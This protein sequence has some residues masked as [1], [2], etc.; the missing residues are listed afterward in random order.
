MGEDAVRENAILF[1]PMGIILGAVVGVADFEIQYQRSLNRY[2][3]LYLNPELA[4]SI[5]GSVFGIGVGGYFFP[6][7]RQLNGLYLSAEVIP[8]ISM[9]IL[10]GFEAM[11][12]WQWITRNGFAISLGAGGVYFPAGTKL[13]L[14]LAT[15]GFAF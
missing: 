11:L 5:S 6:L 13:H 14:H 1:N 2:F 7:G 3:A 10:V 8:I 12:G 9:P 4:F 15:M